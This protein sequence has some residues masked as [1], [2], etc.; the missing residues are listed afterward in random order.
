MLLSKA[1]VSEVSYCSVVAVVFMV[2]GYLHISTR[3]ASKQKFKNIC[4]H[5][6]SLWQG[7]YSKWYN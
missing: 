7:N 6:I 2:Q 1:H 3:I 5:V 4:P